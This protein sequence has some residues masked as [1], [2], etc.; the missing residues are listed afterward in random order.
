MQ[1]PVFKFLKFSWCFQLL[2]GYSFISYSRLCWGNCFFELLSRVVL[3]HSCMARRAVV[4]AWPRPWCSVEA[5]EIT[6]LPQICPS[7]LEEVRS[8][9]ASCLSFIICKIRPVI[10]TFGKR[11]EI[12]WASR[13]LSVQSIRVPWDLWRTPECISTIYCHYWLI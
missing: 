8:F 13:Y 7:L 3:H 11:S 6:A 5:L 2:I 1:K 12:Y 9:Y 10:W 4:G